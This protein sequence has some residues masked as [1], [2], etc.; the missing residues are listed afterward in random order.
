MRTFNQ[1]LLRILLVALLVGAGTWFWGWLVLP[2]DAPMTEIGE[3]ERGRLEAVRRPT[4]ESDRAHHPYQEIDYDEGTEASWSPKGE[5]PILRELV[6]QGL[7]PPVYERVGPE[8]LVLSGPDGIGAYGGNWSDG[9]T[10]DSEVWDRLNRHLSGVTLVR[11]S[12]SGYPIAP[13]VAKSWEASPDLRTWTFHLRRGMRWSDGQPFTAQDMVYWF[14]WELRYFQRIGNPLN[15]VGFRILR[16][17]SDLGRLERVDDHTVRFIFPNPN[18]FFPEILAS[19]SLNG[20]FAPRHYLEKFH[21]ELGDPALIEAIMKQRGLNTRSQV[22][23]EVRR[24][25]NP[26]QPRLSAWTYRR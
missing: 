16:S 3:E 13:H 9:V 10:W 8:P 2:G 20:M 6:E 23:R 22:Y 12:P 1:P 5:A 4:L 25:D 21:P 14:E 26:E 15:L 24:D 19:T 7:L 18:P 17:G 11:W